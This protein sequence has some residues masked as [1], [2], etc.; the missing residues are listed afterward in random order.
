[1]ICGCPLCGAL[2]THIEKGL[3][4]YCKC[5]DCG[6]VCKDCMGGE[7]KKFRHI[8]RDMLEDLKK[9]NPEDLFDES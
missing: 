8:K 5:Q 9:L 1:M 6:R 7:N 3:D 2:T 4:S